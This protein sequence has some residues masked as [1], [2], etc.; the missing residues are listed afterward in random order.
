LAN[1]K[2]SFSDGSAAL[3]L[4]NAILVM[5]TMILKEA[6]RAARDG[7]A[8]PPAKR[9]SLSPTS[10]HAEFQRLRIIEVWTEKGFWPHL[11][12]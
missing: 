4:K 8:P 3:T 5:D 7:F 12:L 6:I 11:E 1:S 9:K 10:H 2:G